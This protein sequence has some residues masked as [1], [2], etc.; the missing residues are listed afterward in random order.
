ME[1]SPW[2]EQ[3]DTVIYALRPP[4]SSAWT[5]VGRSPEAKA[6]PERDPEELSRGMAVKHDRLRG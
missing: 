4:M 3:A 5:C 2:G 6:E 1:H